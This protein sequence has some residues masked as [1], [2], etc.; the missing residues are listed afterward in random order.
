VFSVYSR[1][2]CPGVWIGVGGLV[3][4]WGGRWLGGIVSESVAREMRNLWR[5]VDVYA[6]GFFTHKNTH[7]HTDTNTYTHAHAHTHAHKSRELGPNCMNRQ[8]GVRVCVHEG[9]YRS[10]LFGIE[11]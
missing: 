10:W 11:G 1:D 3:G 5:C 8:S 9:G 2:I 6:N 7:S 4:V